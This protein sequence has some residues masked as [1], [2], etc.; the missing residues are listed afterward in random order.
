MTKIEVYD[1]NGKKKS[2]AEL[3]KVFSAP[4]K[5]E[6]VA[7]VLE[8]MKI[9]QPYGPNPMAGK[10]T[11]ASGQLVRRRHVWKSG[12]GRG[13]SRVPRK[14]TSRKGS[15]FIWEGAQS[16]N[17][18]GGRRAHPPIPISHINI[19]RINKKEK[20]LALKS[21]LS[22]TADSKMV[23]EKY[24]CLA[25]K[26]VEG[27]PFVIEMKNSVKTKQLASG[28]KSMLGDLYCVAE[29]KKSIR[30]TKGKSR[31]RKYKR[32][33]GMLIVIGNEEILKTKLFEVKK[34]RELNL[35]DLA[36]GGLGRLVV[37]TEKAIKE[38]GENFK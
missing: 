22:A 12:Y 13:A 20:V 23:Q 33:A 15:Q 30:G 14:I 11:S 25:D 16:P 38:I 21:A 6:I 8:T 35:T 4:I 28:M 7:K 9:Q 5:E 26:K 1:L 34:A 31:G 10:N 36:S 29:R 17:T 18:K 27:V 24:S 3:P 2:Q 32:S 37:Y 19:K